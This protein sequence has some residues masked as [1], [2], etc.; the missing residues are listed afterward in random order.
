MCCL[1]SG[2]RTRAALVVSDCDRPADLADRLTAISSSF[3]PPRSAN[4]TRT[5][6]EE[7]GSNARDH[8]SWSCVMRGG[9][10]RLRANPRRERLKS[11]RSS[12]RSSATKK[13]SCVSTI[14]RSIDPGP[15]QDALN[16]TV[17]AG[18]AASERPLVAICTAKPSTALARS[19]RS[20]E[21]VD[22]A[23]D[24]G[25]CHRAWYRGVYRGEKTARRLLDR[26]PDY[27]RPCV[28]P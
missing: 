10:G 3:G 14:R 27:N 21:H 7:S 26:R 15:H 24:Q 9:H 5:R 13:K 16:S 8:S 2:L 20:C 1:F 28:W 12:M 18:E 11:V 23:G 22:F 25:P 6:L 4:R 19:L 17:P